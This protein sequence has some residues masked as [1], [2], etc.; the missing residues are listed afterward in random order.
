MDDNNRKPNQKVNFFDGMNPKNTDFGDL[1]SEQIQRLSYAVNDFNG[2]GILQKSP[3]TL[4][5]ILNTASPNANNISFS[6]IN[7]GNYDGKGIFVDRQPIDNQ[8]GDQL[9][10]TLT[11]VDIP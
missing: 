2:S 6:V 5:P 3:I 11:N 1:Q 8:F 7:S 10:V 4:P 9:S